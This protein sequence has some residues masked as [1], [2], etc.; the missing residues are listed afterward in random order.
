ML[1]S[2]VDGI[3]VKSINAV[4][5][6][7][8]SSSGFWDWIG[9]GD[10]DYTLCHRVTYRLV[11]DFPTLQSWQRSFLRSLLLSSSIGDEFIYEIPSGKVNSANWSPIRDFRAYYSIM[12]T[13]APKMYSLRPRPPLWP[14]ACEQRFRSRVS[15]LLSFLTS[16]LWAISG[17]LSPGNRFVGTWTLWLHSHGRNKVDWLFTWYKTLHAT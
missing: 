9:T 12:R 11:E 2:V 17:I 7:T 4:H 15:L 6:G 8:L 16:K 13:L 3:V 1:K 10:A 5:Y 14:N